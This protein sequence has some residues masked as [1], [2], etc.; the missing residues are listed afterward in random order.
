MVGIKE[1][2]KKK[3]YKLI[4][5]TY[6]HEG[7]KNNQTYDRRKATSWFDKLPGKLSP[8]C[9]L[10]PDKI[11]EKIIIYYILSYDYKGNNNQH[12]SIQKLP[13]YLKNTKNKTEKSY[14]IIFRYHL[15][16]TKCQEN[17]DQYLE[18]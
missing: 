15:W 11:S 5:L 14:Q 18:T 7:K 3:W 10:N 17:V 16:K 4:I 2:G 9:L 6:L 13:S 12:I 8:K 1:K